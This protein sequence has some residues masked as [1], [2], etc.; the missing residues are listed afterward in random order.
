MPPLPTPGEFPVYSA[1][2]SSVAVRATTVGWREFF[3]DERLKAIIEA[4]LAHN[5]D[6]AIAV[7]QIDEARGLYRIQNADR[8]PTVGANAGA[9][10]SRIGAGTFG[11]GVT[12]GPSGVT[13]DRY[14]VGVGVSAFELDFWGRVRNLSEAAR[15]R[16]LAT[17]QAQRS[18]R[19]SLIRDVAATYLFSLEAAERIRL[20]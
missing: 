14:T 7:A 6:L 17:V 18:F 19:L 12:A 15:S 16:F 13:I 2:D 4:A 5:R 3:V 1:A 10:R 20:A 11:G 8:L 9:T